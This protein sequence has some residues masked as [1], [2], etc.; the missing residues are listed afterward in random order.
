[1][2]ASVVG[3]TSASEAT[4]RMGREGVRA[5]PRTDEGRVDGA[6]TIEAM[7]VNTIGQVWSMCAS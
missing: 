5:G 4:I 7:D 2:I 3:D 6:P 1:V